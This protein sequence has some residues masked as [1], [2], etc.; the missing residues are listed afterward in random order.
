MIRFL[1]ILSV[2]LCVGTSA[3]AQTD[4]FKVRLLVG[5]DL[6]PPTTPTGLIAIP[7]ATTQID[8]SWDAST[9]NFALGGYQVFRDALQI[10]TTTLTTYSDSGLTPSTTYSYYVTAFDDFLNI[11][12]SSDAVSTTT[13]ALT[14]T[15]TPPIEDFNGGGNSFEVE[16]V[17]FSITPDIYSTSVAWETNRYAQFELRWGRTSSYELGFVTNEL[18][19]REHTTVISDLEPGTTY[20]YQLIAYGY[21]GHRSVLREGRFK[22]LSIPDTVPPANV[23]NLTIDV[24]GDDT[25]LSWANPGDAD[26]SH[27]RIVRNYL[28]YPTDMYDGFIAYQGSADSFFDRNA[29]DEKNVQYY[30][31]FSVDTNGNVSS[32][33][34]GFATKKGHQV[35]PPSDAPAPFDLHVSDVEVYQDGKQIEKTSI[36]ADKPLTIRIAYDKLPERLKA[37]TVVLTHPYNKDAHFT[38]LLRINKDKT[39]YEATVGALRQAGLYPVSVTIFDYEL[40]VSFVI[41]DTFGVVKTDTHEELFGIPLIVTTADMFSGVYWLFLSILLI[42]L[43]FLG[44]LLFFGKKRRKNDD[45][46]RTIHIIRTVIL[47]LLTSGAL[48]SGYI[49]ISKLEAEEPVLAALSIASVPLQIL[50]VGLFVGIFVALL[51]IGVYF[52]FKKSN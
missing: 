43:L 39:Y 22:T 8:L 33:A 32:G 7:V 48:V 34:I 24:R 20:E 30:S 44:Y 19:K 21:D 41:E 15:S 50:Q 5:E 10:A 4:A 28:F 46:W 52:F 17:A 49:L 14:S 11:S 2:L 1:V 47:I 36:D 18:F 29:L 6:T 23:S 45:G 16:L 12:S 25:F 27:V 37:I 3:L 13:F 51:L 40:A 42:L 9:D 35:L 26:F 38:F 31:I